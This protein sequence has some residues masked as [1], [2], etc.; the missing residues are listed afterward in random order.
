VIYHNFYEI[1]SHVWGGSVIDG[2]EEQI[3]TDENVCYPG[4][5][6]EL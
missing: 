6:R 4:D 3:K 5:E 1:Y 2:V